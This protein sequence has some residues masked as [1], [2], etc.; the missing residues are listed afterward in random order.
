MVV[1]RLDPL[2]VEPWEMVSAC[3]KAL[4]RGF[5]IQ[6]CGSGMRLD[7]GCWCVGA[8]AMGDTW[9]AAE[10]G[11][12]GK[13]QRLVGKDPGL[14]NAKHGQVAMTPLVCACYDGHL[15]MQWLLDQGA[16]INEPF[17]RGQTALYMAVGQGFIPVVKML[18]ERGADPTIAT[19]WGS[20][21]LMA[22]ALWGNLEVVRFLLGHPS[23]K[24]IIN[25]RDEDGHTALW[26][27]SCMGGGG[28]VR[29]LL[30]SGADPTI[31]DNDGASPM[32]IAKERSAGDDP[33][34]IS[35]DAE[36]RR[37]C[38]AALEVSFYLSLV[39]PSCVVIS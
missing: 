14:L 28:A 4:C 21:P 30:E 12:L 9:Q 35:A 2:A 27:A 24:T 38:V 17:K 32:T 26:W 19:D 33:D 29:A 23:T 31:A 34:D 13:V 8:G 20:T 36:G 39:C 1:G 25:R 11:D 6:R 5:E 16:A 37:E 3:Q 15:V 7:G 18:L 10:Q 22:G